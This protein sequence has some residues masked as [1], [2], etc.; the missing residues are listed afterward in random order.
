MKK[1][2]FILFLSLITPFCFSQNRAPSC[3]LKYHDSFQGDILVNTIRVDIPSPLYTYYCALQWNAGQEGGGYCGIQDHPNGH[4]FIYSIWNSPSTNQPITA[5]YVASGTNTE[6]FGG[7]GTGLKSWNFNLGWNTQQWYSFVSRAWNSNG[8]TMFGYWIYKHTEGQW[9]HL[10]TMDYPVPN[11]KFNGGTGSFIE[12]WLGNGSNARTVGHKYGWKR[13]TNLSWSSFSQATFERVS[14]DPGAA[15]YI[16]KYNGGIE[17]NTHYFMKTGGTTTPVNNV[18]GAILNLNSNDAAPNL[19]FQKGEVSNLSLVNTGPNINFTWTTNITKVPQFSYHIEVYNN[20]AFTGTPIMQMSE[21]IPHKR[22]HTLNINS[23]PNNSIYYVKFYITDIFG[24]Q[25]SI[26]FQNFTKGTLNVSDV[27]HN[28]TEVKYFPNPTDRY[29]NIEFGKSQRDIELE[30][31]DISGK[32]LK[33][34]SYQNISKI[35]VDLAKF[36]PGVYLLKTKGQNDQ[37][38]KVIKK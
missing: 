32:L 8:H 30:I 25:S 2:T 1:F 34:E 23:L 33:K 3:W 27:S 31:L 13:N 16:N 19:Y 35:T 24:N 17:T 4:N 12:D 21:N 37:V 9:F 14:P 29:I 36:K 7:E 18:S 10:V 11:V 5:A 38:F 20:P 28:N 15:N 6:A 26:L 22:N